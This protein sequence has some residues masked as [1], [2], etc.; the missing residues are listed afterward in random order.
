MTTYCIYAFLRLYGV[1]YNSQWFRI[2][3]YCFA[4]TSIQMLGP[5]NWVSTVLLSSHASCFQG[6]LVLTIQTHSLPTDWDADRLAFVTLKNNL[7]V[8]SLRAMMMQ[9]LV[10]MLIAAFCFC[11]FLYALWTY[12][13]NYLQADPRT[14]TPSNSLSRNQAK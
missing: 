9:F 8:L 7:M 13:Y 1:Y 2:F 4:I 12:V 3:E 10:L 11:G 5:A 6:S 14:Q